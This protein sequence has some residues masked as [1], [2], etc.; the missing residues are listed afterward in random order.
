MTRPSDPPPAKPDGRPPAGLL[1]EARLSRAALDANLSALLS[2][3]AAADAVVD[4]R[5][6]AYGHGLSAIV[7]AAAEH[8]IRRFRVSPGAA[9]AAGLD[10]EGGPVD[11][12][13]EL[14]AYGFDST[15]DLDLRPILTLVGEVVAV[16]QVPAGSA[17]SYGYTYRTERSGTIALVGLGYADGVPR[18][19]SST[20][21]A[22]IGGVPA[23][24]AG[25]IAM[26]QFV[27]DL[28]DR[29][30]AVGDEVAVWGD[31][32]DGAPALRDWAAIARRA[33]QQVTA[34]LGWRV[35]RRWIE[36]GVR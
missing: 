27:L 6:D 19:G 13:S 12:A 2:A 17:V 20:A 25:R 8:G 26:D 31:P 11:A 16:K 7:G 36:G 32:R 23:I 29:S 3:H 10:A 14:A 34:G 30:A 35:T 5:A 33:P 9:L 21:H 24:V 28:G 22:A 1:R 18:L 4:A 15:G